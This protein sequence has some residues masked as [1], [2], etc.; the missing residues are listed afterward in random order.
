MA[1]A[2]A[3]TRAVLPA[4]PGGAAGFTLVELLAAVTLTAIVAASAFAALDLFVEAD[5]RAID[6]TQRTIDVD[7]ALHLLRRDVAMATSLDLRSTELRL[8]HPDGA[9][10]VYAFPGAGTELHRLAGAGLASLLVPLQNLLLAGETAVTYDERGHQ[11]DGT[12]SASAVLQGLTGITVAPIR[13]RL[14]GAVIGVVVRVTWPGD[15]AAAVTATAAVALP[16]AEAN[17]LR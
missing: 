6:A 8:E 14:G 5:L 9:A 2:R 11:R 16:L 3:L 4:R 13:A 1:G 12:W 7:R 10:I 17:A 15:G